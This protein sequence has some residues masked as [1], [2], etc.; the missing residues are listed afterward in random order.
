MI[1]FVPI[2]FLLFSSCVITK[3][4]DDTLSGRPQLEFW[5]WKNGDYNKVVGHGGDIVAIGGEKKFLISLLPQK[6]C[7]LRYIDGDTDVA[8]DCGGKE[9][10][11]I[12]F[13]KYYTNHPEVIS[14]S[15]YS[16]GIRTGYFYPSLRET[17]DVLPIVF[18]CPY[19]FTANNVSVCTRPIS[20][21]FTISIYLNNNGELLYR[22]QC[23]GESLVEERFS[24]NGP[25]IKKFLINRDSIGYCVVGVGFRQGELKKSHIL[26][27]RFYAPIYEPNYE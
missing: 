2:L 24:I 13:G 20:Y 4:F 14:F 19:Q 16:D 5:Y 15:V 11:E 8:K 1:R 12:D 26:H 21:S 3:K 10:I 18:K 17:K 6:K 7:L 27:I 9:S 25:E 22:K 23:V